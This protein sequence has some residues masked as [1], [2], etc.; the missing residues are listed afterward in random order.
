MHV[1][2]DDPAFLSVRL[3]A[4]LAGSVRALSIATGRDDGDIVTS[5]L[6]TY[7]ADQRQRDTVEAH[8]QRALA[9]Y[10]R[11]YLVTAVATL[12]HEA[13]LDDTTRHDVERTFGQI[14]RY[15]ATELEWGPDAHTVKIAMA[16]SGHTAAQA[17]DTAVKMVRNRIVDE[18]LL[19]LDG[20]D[21]G[22]AVVSVEELPHG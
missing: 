2:P 3:P 13:P 4:E 8:F 9:G 5:A 11:A 16:V 6:R 19:T 17:M 21:G 10:P 12:H 1:S 15:A 7:L 18:H 20:A 22:I 14:N